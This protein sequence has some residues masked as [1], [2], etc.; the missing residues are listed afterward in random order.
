VTAKQS[1]ARE[2][3]HRTGVNTLHEDNSTRAEDDCRTT[4]RRKTS[5]NAHASVVVATC[6]DNRVKR[7][8]SDLVT[9][10]QAAVRKTSSERA[11]GTMMAERVKRRR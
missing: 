10:K 7:A 1:T 2:F 5:A 8:I 3:V 6:D 4:D 9:D 11:A